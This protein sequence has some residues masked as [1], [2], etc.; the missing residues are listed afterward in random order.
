MI[1]KDDIDSI[2]NKC[3]KTPVCVNFKP[4]VDDLMQCVCQINEDGSLRVC[5]LFS[6]DENDKIKNQE[7]KI[8]RYPHRAKVRHTYNGDVIIEKNK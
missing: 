2:S 1:R 8:I 4:D 5:D 7:K 3:Y 6:D